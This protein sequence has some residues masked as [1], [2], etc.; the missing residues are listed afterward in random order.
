MLDDFLYNLFCQFCSGALLVGISHFL[1]SENIHKNT[2]YNVQYKVYN[3][4]YNT[5]QM[6]SKDHLKIT[7][8][9]AD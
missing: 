4:Q 8:K 9:P 7:A 1:I 2:I 3:I 6:N 5:M